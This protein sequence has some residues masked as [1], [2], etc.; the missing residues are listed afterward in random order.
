MP[1][2]DD[3]ENRG[4]DTEPDWDAVERRFP[5]LKKGA[6]RHIYVDAMPHTLVATLRKRGYDVRHLGA[7]PRESPDDLRA[8][9][10]AKSQAIEE[11]TVFVDKTQLDALKL[12]MYA[13]GMLD[14]RYNP[15]DK[16]V[17]EVVT[18]ALQL[19]SWSRSQHT[20][21]DNSTVQ[22]AQTPA[23]PPADGVSKK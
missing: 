19:L 13:A 8:Y 21:R 3:T 2:R 20:L 7:L 15:P 16:G 6:S 1:R 10:F 17:A 23:S 12:Q 18:D 4:S 11:G 5:F 9:L 22:A 14:K